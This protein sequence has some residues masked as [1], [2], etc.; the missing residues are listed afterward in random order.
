ME[1]WN[2]PFYA[3]IILDIISAGEVFIIIPVFVAKRAEATAL[4]VLLNKVDDILDCKRLQLEAPLSGI[5]THL[6][7]KVVSVALDQFLRQFLLQ[8]LSQFVGIN[9]AQS[10]HQH[11]G[12]E[13]EEETEGIKPKQI[14]PVIQL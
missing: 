3:G 5:S 10:D 11:L 7:I 14:Q 4:K 6:E 13:E 9:K 1:N 12:K 2:L 8:E